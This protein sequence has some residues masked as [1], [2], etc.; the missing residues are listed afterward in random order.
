M[1]YIGFIML[2]LGYFYRFLNLIVA[3]YGSEELLFL[4]ILY[5]II[6]NIVEG[7]LVTVIVSIAW[8]WSIT[9]LRHDPTY[10]LIGTV[11]TLINIVCLILDGSA[12]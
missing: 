1:V 3:Y 12:E 2:G 5:L 7:I 6:K 10:I 11:I 9:H 8:G 4:E